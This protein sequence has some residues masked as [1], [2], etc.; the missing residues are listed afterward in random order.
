MQRLSDYLTSLMHDD[1]LRIISPNS[2]V[3]SPQTTTGSGFSA[4]TDPSNSSLS[5]SASMANAS[6]S[7]HNEENDVVTYESLYTSENQT[8][9]AA[10][11]V[12]ASDRLDSS[13][14]ADHSIGDHINLVDSFGRR[15]ENHFTEF[16]MRQDS[17]S[18]N[19]TSN[20][21]ISC[22]VFS[23]DLGD[24][25][26][27]SAD[28]ATTQP[29]SHPIFQPDAKMR[30]FGHRNA[31]TIIN[32][33]TFWGRNHVMSGSDCGHVFIWNRWTGKVVQVL[34]ADKRVVNRVRPHP[35][36][37]VLATAGIDYDIKLWIPSG[38]SLKI[39]R[40]VDIE[41]VLV[42]QL[43]YIYIYIG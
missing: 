17:E 31:R 43:L 29:H 40:Q 35:F 16:R 33:A 8:A 10:A 19:S 5:E 27:F 39:Q 14:S 9:D 11:E 34:Q 36:E 18:S 6:A 3:G 20:A 4:M 26:F 2:P 28:L 12:S 7:G 21:A 42:N 23:Q 30:Y 22:D 24:H 25:N 1:A 32:E 13:S 41:E 38:E 15:L 37:P